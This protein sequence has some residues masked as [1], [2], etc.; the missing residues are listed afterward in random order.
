MPESQALAIVFKSNGPRRIGLRSGKGREK[1]K[2]RTERTFRHGMGLPLGCSWM[3][4]KP[5]ALRS[6]AAR[7][8]N[9]KASPAHNSESRGPAFLFA[10]TM[11]NAGPME[12]ALAAG[13]TETKLTFSALRNPVLSG[14]H[15]FYSL[16]KVRLWLYRRFRITGHSSGRWGDTKKPDISDLC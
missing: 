14:V 5:R 4:R 9:N 8:K 7:W 12:F 11:R 10:F 6:S 15:Q 13:V 3:A 16:P 2:R 1:G